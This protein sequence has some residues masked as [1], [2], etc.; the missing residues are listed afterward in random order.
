MREYQIA[1]Q[2]VESFYQAQQT[3]EMDE[4]QKKKQQP[5]R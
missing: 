5:L 2:N 3:L 4:Q 1:K